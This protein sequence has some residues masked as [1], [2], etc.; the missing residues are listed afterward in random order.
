MVNDIRVHENRFLCVFVLFVL[1][2]AATGITCIIVFKDFLKKNEYN[3]IMMVAVPCGLETSIVDA[4]NELV[5]ARSI[6]I[7]IAVRDPVL[8]LF[9]TD[10]MNR[11]GNNTFVYPDKWMNKTLDGH[12]KDFFD[13]GVDYSA[14]TRYLDR[15]RKEVVTAIGRYGKDYVTDPLIG[16]IEVVAN[17][18]RGIVTTLESPTKRFRQLL[19]ELDV[20]ASYFVYHNGDGNGNVSLPLVREFLKEEIALYD[21]VARH[22]S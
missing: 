4:I 6:S 12:L 15:Y 2:I 17:S 19:Y 13:Y 3:N 11:D 18:Y 10:T 22:T 8:R 14:S 9:C 7:V 16:A 20:N 21:Y 5:M 1:G